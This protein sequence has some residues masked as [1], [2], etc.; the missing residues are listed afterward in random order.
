MPG[1]VVGRQG[2]TAFRLVLDGWKG[3]GWL[4][5]VSEGVYAMVA[6]IDES[7][8]EPGL[9]WCLWELFGIDASG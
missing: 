2:G 4:E 6:L 3:F 9:G 1:D 8:K 5:R 7:W